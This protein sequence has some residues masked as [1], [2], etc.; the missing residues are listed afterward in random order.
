MWEGFWVGIATT[1]IGIFGTVF[2]VNQ[3]LQR[4]E[5][6]RRS[7]LKLHVRQRVSRIAFHE[8]DKMIAMVQGHLEGEARLHSERD[9]KG[10][11]RIPDGFAAQVDD[12]S[13]GIAR[14]LGSLDGREWTSI[15]RLFDRMAMEYARLI[16]LF[17]YE[18]DAEV[19]RMM[20]RVEESAHRLSGV[21]ADREDRLGNERE[22]VAEEA[23]R[24]MDKSIDVIEFHMKRIMKVNLDILRRV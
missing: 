18:M 17:G 16:S 21:I 12:A 10:I 9:E 23:P 13:D 20:L 4:V 22:T 5:E 15:A 1:C 19:L 2:L 14:R 6:R 3:L 7:G 8:T 11:N 24:T